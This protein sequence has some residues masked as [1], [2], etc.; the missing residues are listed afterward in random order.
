MR[1]DTLRY[2]IA[3]RNENDEYIEELFATYEEAKK[4]AEEISESGHEVYGILH[5][6][7]KSIEHQLINNKTILIPP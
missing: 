2:A 1:E 7:F 4:T 5:W 6:Y 3:Y